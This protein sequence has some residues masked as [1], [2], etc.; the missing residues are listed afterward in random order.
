MLIVRQ[1]GNRRSLPKAKTM[2][3][4]V[5]KKAMAAL[6]SMTMM[7]EIIA[8]VPAREQVASWKI[9]MKGKPS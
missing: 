4:A 2:R 8:E 5:A 3:E 1:K 9:C 6:M 7:I